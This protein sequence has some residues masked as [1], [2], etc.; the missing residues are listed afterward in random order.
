MRVWSTAC[1]ARGSTEDGRLPMVM[2][3]RARSSAL[4]A[5]RPR[6]D[7]AEPA[8]VHHARRDDRPQ[9]QAT[10]SRIPLP[11]IDIPHFRYGKNGRAASA[12]ARA[13]SASRSARAS[14]G[15][16]A[17][18]GRR[19]SPASTCSRSSLTLDEL[20]A[21]LG[22]ELRA[23]AHRAQGQ[24][25]NI[26]SEKDKYTSIRRAGPGVAA[27]L[28]AHVH[29]RRCK[30][31]IAIGHLRPGRP[32]HRPDPRGQALPLLAARRR[33]RES[34]RGHHL[35]DGRLGLDERRAEGDR[36]H[37][38][39]LDRHLAAQPVQGHRDA[40]HHPRRRGQGGRRATRST[41]RARAAARGSL[42]AY[43]LC[44]QDDRRP[45]SRRPSGTSTPSTSPTATTGG[46][47]TDQCVELLEDA[48]P[49][50]GEPV[51][52]RPGREPVRLGRVH[53]GPERALRRATTAWSCSEIKDKDAH[54]RVDQGLPGQGEI[55]NG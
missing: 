9:G 27:P 46:D 16:G 34:Q 8:E 47:D 7:Q 49:A 18:P 11:Q 26:V 23:A 5:D 37:R 21:I 3:D 22:E 45:T 19:A 25:A 35:H 42:S 20:A 4:P 39:V 55:G 12:R 54:H 24:A 13:K 44:A 15:D 40:L 2:Q 14:R 43:K 36:P 29:G 50:E 38:G 1:T 52:L 28:Q 32:D 41:T 6:Q 51:L 53:Q 30:R 33:C 10:S 48:D 17:R 31:Q